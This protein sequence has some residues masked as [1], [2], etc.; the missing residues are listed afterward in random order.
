MQ[1]CHE[2]KYTANILDIHKIY[3]KY[4]GHPLK[5]NI[6]EIYWT[7]INWKYTGHPVIKMAII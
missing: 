4:T 7:S 6:L 5:G 3:W 2:G 1:K